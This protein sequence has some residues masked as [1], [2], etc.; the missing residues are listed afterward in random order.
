MFGRAGATLPPELGLLSALEELVLDQASVIG[1]IPPE[2][3]G[4]TSLS[5]LNLEHTLL[6]GTIP[7]QLGTL[8][9]LLEG[10]FTSTFTLSGTIP[11][12]LASLNAARRWFFPGANNPPPESSGL[13]GPIPGVWD[14]GNNDL[15]HAFLHESQLCILDA[16]S[17][18]TAVGSDPSWLGT[19]ETRYCDC[20]FY[21]CT[22]PLT[23][24][25]S[26]R[27]R[28]PVSQYP[29]DAFCCLPTTT[30]VDVETFLT[31]S[32]NVPLFPDTLSFDFPL[33]DCSSDPCVVSPFGST[34]LGEL[35]IAEGVTGTIPPSISGLTALEAIA[36]SGVAV[37]SGPIPTVIGNLSSLTS[38]VFSDSSLTGTIPAEL[39]LLTKLV[40]FFLYSS[41]LMGPHTIPPELST[42]TSLEELDFSNVNLS[43]TIPPELGLLANLRTLYL[44]SNYLE[45]PVPSSFSSMILDHSDFADNPELCVAD[46][47]AEDVVWSTCGGCEQNPPPRCGCKWFPCA[48]PKFNDDVKATVG[49]QQQVADPSALPF[50]VTE[51][52]CCGTD[53]CAVVVPPVEEPVIRAQISMKGSRPGFVTK[54]SSPTTVLRLPSSVVLEPGTADDLAAHTCDAANRGVLFVLADD[55]VGD[56]LFM[57]AFDGTDFVWRSFD[58]LAA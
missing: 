51:F 24:R 2:L 4:L 19:N 47:V 35:L 23:K 8:P 11:P 5:I 18:A 44:S 1:T 37:V 6:S 41:P 56:A 32:T 54:A 28:A 46:A 53:P 12:E 40:W 22:P 27:P 3:S 39:S 57:C 42:L 55:T 14:P 33:L 34:Y 20:K 48:L 25:P 7:P 26:S 45:G 52:F 31:L 49:V 21:T 58:T 43:G 50:Y 16:A 15:A 9:L 29:D 13:T 36:F 10:R 30:F 38:I 17:E